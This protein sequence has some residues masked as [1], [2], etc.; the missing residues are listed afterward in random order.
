MCCR[1][2]ERVEDA[3]G[4]FGK[5]LVGEGERSAPRLPLC[6]PIKGDDALAGG[7]QPLDDGG[8]GG[9][10]ASVASVLSPEGVAVFFLS[11]A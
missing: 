10:G 6:P 4:V 5:E 2:A 3:D 9:V 8:K 1:N 11:E 7:T